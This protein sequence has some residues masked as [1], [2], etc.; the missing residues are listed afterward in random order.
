MSDA[1]DFWRDLHDAIVSV[2]GVAADDDRATHIEAVMRETWRGESI[3]I[4]ANQP[5]RP[6]LAPHLLVANSYSGRKR[7]LKETPTMLSPIV[8]IERRASGG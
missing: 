6:A 2:Y 1:R 7:Q 8:M 5:G 3:S 4:T